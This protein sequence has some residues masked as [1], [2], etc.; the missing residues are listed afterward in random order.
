MATVTQWNPFGVSL[1]VTATGS[2]IVRKSATQ[3]TVLISASWQT[4]W[5]G[6]QTN[7]GMLA[8]SGGGS[9][10]INTFGKKASSGSCTSTGT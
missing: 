1:N 2:N 7:F 9:S 4:Y 8:S 3:F 6:N 10:V 5:S